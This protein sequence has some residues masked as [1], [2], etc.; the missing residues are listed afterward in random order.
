M[1]IFWHG[2]GMTWLGEEYC[3][4]DLTLRRHM[5]LSAKSATGRRN[6]PTP[7]PLY[8]RLSYCLDQSCSAWSSGSS[9]AQKLTRRRTETQLRT[10]TGHPLPAR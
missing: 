3:S 4:E 1:A 5:A 2:R 9:C 7:V 10:A 6:A 8:R